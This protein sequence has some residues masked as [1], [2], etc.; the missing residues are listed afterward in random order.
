MVNVVND[1]DENN[2]ILIKSVYNGVEFDGMVLEGIEVCYNEFVIFIVFGGV[3]YFWSELGQIG[4]VFSG[5]VIGLV[6]IYV[7]IIDVF[8]CVDVDIIFLFVYLQIFVLG[9]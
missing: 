2:N 9:F 1:V 7:I 5:N 8:G 3:S 4:F 6:D